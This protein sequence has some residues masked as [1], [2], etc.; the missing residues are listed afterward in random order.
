MHFTASAPNCLHYSMN[1]D[2][3]HPSEKRPKTH[4][5]VNM[6]LNCGTREVDESDRDSLTEATARRL[7][8]TRPVL[9]YFIFLNRLQQAERDL[10]D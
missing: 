1:T 2:G 8:V 10:R 9:Q 5:V 4:L 6:Q 3:G 7:A